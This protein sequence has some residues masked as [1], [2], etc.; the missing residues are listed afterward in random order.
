MPLPHLTTPEGRVS[1]GEA[2]L[3]R[4]DQVKRGFGE[5][6]CSY[7]LLVDGLHD[8]LCQF[9]GNMSGP[10]MNEKNRAMDSY[11]Y[12][13]EIAR[14]CSSRCPPSDAEPADIVAY[15]STPNWPISD[16]DFLSDIETNKKNRDKTVC[17]HWGCSVWPNQAAAQHA[18]TLFKWVRRKYVVAGRLEPSDGQVLATPTGNQPEHF[19]FWKAVGVDVST[20]FK[21]IFR[22]S[23]GEG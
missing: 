10:W 19:T 16:A 23:I 12:H 5:A 13:P 14:Y 1:G 3:R 6:P 22:P 21:V 7:R 17:Q 15:R 9:S 2:C 8:R 4:K 20:K 18:W 11:K